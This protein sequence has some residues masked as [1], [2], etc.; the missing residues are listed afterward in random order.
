MDTGTSLSGLIDREH[1]F[2]NS[3]LGV[4]AQAVSKHGSAKSQ[5]VIFNTGDLGK[6]WIFDSYIYTHTSTKIHVVQPPEKL[7][8]L[9]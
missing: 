2:M 7:H 8:Y 3:E 1:F 6:S 9:I 4:W 5:V